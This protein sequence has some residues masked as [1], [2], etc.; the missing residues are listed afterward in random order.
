MTAGYIQAG[1]D[2]L[3]EPMQKVTD[4]FKELIGI[5]EPEGEDVVKLVREPQ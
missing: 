1:P 3:R 4:R 2:R 5:A